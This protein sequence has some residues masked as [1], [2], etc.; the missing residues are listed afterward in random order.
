MTKSLASKPDASPWR[1]RDAA[2]W[3][4]L[5]ASPSFALM[6]WLAANDAPPAALC[7]SAASIPPLGGMAAMYLL[8]CLFHLA[9]WLKLVFPGR[10]ARG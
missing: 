8:M 9:P 6:A 7:S 10:W 2:G 1:A 4:A 3:L 5:A